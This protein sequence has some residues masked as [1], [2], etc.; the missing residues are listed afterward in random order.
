MTYS[1]GV[2]QAHGRPSKSSECSLRLRGAPWARAGN[3]EPAFQRDEEGGGR[4]A[5][6]LFGI[7]ARL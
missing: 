3:D 5:T 7:F 6:D 1:G 4:E 2:R